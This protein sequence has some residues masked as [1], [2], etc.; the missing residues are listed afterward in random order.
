MILQ[1]TRPVQGGLR[2]EAKLAIL[3][4]HIANA[5]TAGFKAD[6]LSFDH[7]LKANLNVDFTQGDVNTSGNKLDVALTDEGFFKIQT[8]NGIRYTRNGRF[9]INSNGKLVTDNGNFVLGKKGEITINGTDVFING[10][11]D[12]HVDGTKIDKLKIVTFKSLQNL[13]KEGSSLFVNKGQSGNEIA[14]E[15]ISVQQG[16]LEMSNVSTVV[17]MVKMIE[18]VRKYESFQKMIHS[19]DEIDSKAANEIGRP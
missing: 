10:D 18:A 8:Q 7:K 1:M 16:A 13:Q 17:E 11:G 19:F 6:V 15:N 4:N 5:N 2:Q 12:I 14:P 3:S 9:S